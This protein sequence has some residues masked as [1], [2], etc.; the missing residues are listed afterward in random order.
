MGSHD[1]WSR[2]KTVMD[3]HGQCDQTIE[4]MIVG[5]HYMYWS[6][7]QHSIGMD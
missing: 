2:V 3:S 5:I 1:R 4:H 7:R 6:H